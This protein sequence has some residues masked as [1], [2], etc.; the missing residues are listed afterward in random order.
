LAR[1][2]LLRAADVAE[3]EIRGDRRVAARAGALLWERISAAFGPH[4]S[5]LEFAARHSGPGTYGLVALRDMAA[6]SVRDALGRHCR[7]HRLINEDVSALI[8]ETASSA[9][10][11]LTTAAGRLGLPPAMAEAALAAYVVHVRVWT[12]A[13][14]TPEEVRFEHERPADVSAYERFFRCPVQFGQSVTSI[15]FSRA[16]L[17]LPHEHAQPELCEYLENRAEAEMARLRSRDLTLLVYRTVSDRLSGD[18]SIG[19]VARALGLGART[20]QRRLKE[21]GVCYQDLVDMV[22]HHRAL[23]RMHGPEQLALISEH[24][25]FSDPRAFRRAFARW[26]GVSPDRYRRTRQGTRAA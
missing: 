16:V 18:V 14:A 13:D 5:G 21:D 26:T 6:S 10:L 11:F 1:E 3:E 19:A 12:G 22:R 8:L 17:D 7:H 20:L 23:E 24:L 15:R 4:G 25:G 9:T 2:E